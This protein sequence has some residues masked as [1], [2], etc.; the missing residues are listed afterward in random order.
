ML[1]NRNDAPAHDKYLITG[2]TISSTGYSQRPGGKRADRLSRT[3]LLT[4]NLFIGKG[5]IDHSLGS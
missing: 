5:L 4:S 1:L 3:R 2:E